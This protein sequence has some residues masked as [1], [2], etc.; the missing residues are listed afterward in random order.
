MIENKYIETLDD[1]DKRFIDYRIREKGGEIEALNSYLK[2]LD[3]SKIYKDGSRPTQ[4][5]NYG[6]RV[7][8]ASFLYIINNTTSLNED[9]KVRYLNLLYSKHEENLNF[10]KTNLPIYYKKQSRTSSSNDSRTTRAKDM[11][12]DNILDVT[13]GSAKTVRTKENASIRKARAL[14]NKSV[15][16]A[17]NNFKVNK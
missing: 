12:S 2:D 10:E 1:A 9:T 8:I 11:F 4:T 5:I 16:F 17:F 13:K 6:Y 3:C 15:S 7:T 14:S